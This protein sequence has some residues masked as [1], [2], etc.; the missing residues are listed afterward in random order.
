MVIFENMATGYAWAIMNKTIQAGHIEC[1]QESHI[2]TVTIANEEKYNALSVGMWQ[3]L[4]SVFQDLSAKADLRCVIVRGKGVK[5]FAAGADITEFEQ[6]RKTREQVTEYHEH[7]VLEALLAIS[8]CPVPV[9]AQIQGAC[10][11]GGLEIASVCDLRIAGNSA[12]LGIPIR[13]L[14]FSLA[15]G[16]LQ[17]LVRLVG[18]AVAA[19]LLYEGRMLGA[20]EALSKGLLT[21]VVDDD[22][23][24][25]EAMEM[26]RRIAAGAPLAAR[27]HKQL[28]RRLVTDPSPV[29]R[30]ERLAGYAFADTQDYQIGVR[31]FLDKTMPVF[32]GR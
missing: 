17:G 27:T 12:R 5:S 30:E 24:E 7:T 6:V 25:R 29:T 23:L 10:A 3:D 18:P 26:A 1:H 21:R 9:V 28:I 19:E 15:L 14:G 20:Q 16:E 31:A 22:V 4:K 11:G 8:D 32:T 2:A 13:M